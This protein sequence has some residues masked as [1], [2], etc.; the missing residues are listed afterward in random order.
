MLIKKKRDGTFVRT[1]S[2][3]SMK[4]VSKIVLSKKSFERSVNFVF[5]DGKVV[6]A[7]ERIGRSIVTV[8]RVWQIRIRIHIGVALVRN[9]QIG[10][11]SENGSTF[12]MIANGKRLLCNIKSLRRGLSLIIHQTEEKS[13][14]GSDV[15]TFVH[16][17]LTG[18]WTYH[19]R[20]VSETSANLNFIENKTY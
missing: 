12:A 16:D 9:V 7:H 17:R 4:S 3:M 19:P 1:V 6:V 18:R 15:T 14:V 10:S 20:N 11:S 8:V 2:G 13:A 5:D